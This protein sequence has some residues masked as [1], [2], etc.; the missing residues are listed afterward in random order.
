MGALL[1]IIIIAVSV[2]L[3]AFAVSI[4]GGIKA[5]RSSWRDTIKIGLFFG[6]FQAAMP[7][8]GWG[9]GVA[10]RGFVTSVS[11]WIACILLSVIGIKMIFDV[12]A[13]DDK[14]QKQ[15]NLL[16][17]KT[18]LLMA[19]ATSIDALVVGV[20]LSLVELPLL[21]SVLIIGMTTFAFSIL[22]FRFGG[23]LGSIFSKKIEIVGGLALI[24]IGVHLVLT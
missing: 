23:K 21:L 13:N 6:G 12:I 24:A 20:T 16:D 22:G 7:L 9:M 19:I 5:K 4:V 17:T 1:T 15:K 10:L 8:V 3:D 18:L 14:N 11:G 2:S